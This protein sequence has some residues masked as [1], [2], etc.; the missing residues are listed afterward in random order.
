MIP[1]LPEGAT[2]PGNQGR[3]TQQS[4]EDSDTVTYLYDNDGALST[5]ID[6]ASGS[7]TKYFYDFAGRLAKFT[8]DRGSLARRV[9]YAY[10][11]ENQVSQK[12]EFAGSVRQNTYFRYDDFHRRTQVG[13][14][15]TW[16][17]YTYDTLGRVE[18]QR[19]TVSG[20]DILTE[21]VTYNKANQVQSIQKV[22]PENTRTHS[23]TYDANGN[24][25]TVTVGNKTIR[26]TYDTAGQLI[27]EDD[28]NEC[29]TTVWTY[30]N[31]GNI[32]TE[33]VYM[34]TLGT[35]QDLLETN[36]YTY[37]NSNWGDLLTAYN[38]QSITYDQIGNPLTYNNG[39]AW[40]FTWEHGRQLATMSDGTTTWTNTYNSDGLRTSRTNGTTTYNYYYDGT[41]LVNVTG[42]TQNIWLF[43][44]A[45]RPV[46]IKYGD[47]ATYHYELN[48]QGDVIAILDS[49]GNRVVE[50]T[51]D[52]WGNILSI[53][54]SKKD[55][56]GQAN[57]LRYRGYVYDNETGLYYV[58]SRYYDPE[59]GRWINADIP[60]TLPADFENFAQYN[61]FAYC[62]NNPVNMSDETGTWP[63]WVKK[64]VAVVTAA[65]VVVAATAITVATCGAGSIA[66]VAM[67]TAT[68]TLTAKATEVAVLQVKKGKSEGK[69]G[70]QIAKD[71]VESIYDNGLKIVGLTP[72]IK[73]AGIA[74]NHGLSA[75]V[76]KGFGGT[77]T[78]SATLKSPGGKALPYAFVAIAWS[79]TIISAFSNDPVTKANARGYVLK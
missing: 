52:A 58:S 76:E 20:A 71:A 69:S 68:A 10:N 21:T 61:L 66:G 67:I 77:Q 79:H 6:S 24:I 25:A 14:N 11:E 40:T 60:E 73:S 4:F 36:S 78:L 9:E 34:Y 41:Q 57:P 18:T 38:G 23:Y 50:Y 53:T 62:F 2:P 5:V 17:S 43:Y 39:T 26:Y 19:F 13:T 22:T 55:T 15:S 44:D 1:K 8:E 42:G 33:K 35:P 45:N 65:A 28:P 27:R 47:T 72:V 56:L 70:S 46:I 59:I 29:F 75:I 16:W 49:S 64:A 3:L 7:K 74:F 54:G 12:S 31:A 48:L 32:L 30:D 63:S 37:G 51:Y